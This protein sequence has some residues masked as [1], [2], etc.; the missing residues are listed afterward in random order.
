MR[1]TIDLPDPVFREVKTRAVQ[2]Q[3]TLKELL[4]RFILAGLRGDDR[5]ST[6]RPSR[7]D[8]LPVAIKRNQERAF[9]PNLSNEEL[10]EI[11]EKEDLEFIRKTAND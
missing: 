11:L 4:S 1:T 9:T 7:R 3:T 10:A 5:S 2:E 8:S 6:A